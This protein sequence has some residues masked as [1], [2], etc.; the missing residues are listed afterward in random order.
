MSV[1]LRNLKIKTGAVKRTTKEY[2]YYF[3][4]RDREQEK[5]KKM[6]SDGADPYDVKQQENVVQESTVMI[7]EARKSLEALLAD[8]K[9]F[10][11]ENSGT[12]PADSNEMEDAQKVITEADAAL[13]G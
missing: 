8:L 3:K 11:K 9:A 10:A 2:L 1:E 12:L 4:E 5:L 13:A 6:E 7:P